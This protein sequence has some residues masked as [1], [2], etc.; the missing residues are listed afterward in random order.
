METCQ[1]SDLRVYK[2]FWQNSC[3]HA[4]SDHITEPVPPA[5]SRGGN[6]RQPA[7]SEAWKELWP[8]APAEPGVLE[9]EN[10]VEKWAMEEK[11]WGQNRGSLLG[12]VKDRRGE[13]ER[14]GLEK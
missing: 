9:E 10:N 6:Q 2:F 3:F 1:K 11:G 4:R 12:N 5:L 13:S 7:L 14:S 8:G